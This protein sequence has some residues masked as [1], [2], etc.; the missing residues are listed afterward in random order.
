MYTHN[1]SGTHINTLSFDPEVFDTD[2]LDSDGKPIKSRLR[3]RWDKL[4]EVIANPDMA[5]AIPWYAGAYER[6]VLLTLG[7]AVGSAISLRDSPNM[8]SAYLLGVL[9]Y[10]ENAFAGGIL[11]TQK[12]WEITL[13]P[14]TASKLGIADGDKVLLFRHPI[15]AILAMEVRGSSRLNACCIGLPVGR[16]VR[17]GKLVTVPEILGGDTDGEGY[18]VCAI[19]TN[20]CQVYVNS[21][22]EDQWP[23]RPEL[24]QSDIVLETEEPIVEDP[25]GILL[26]K[27]TQKDAVGPATN[28]SDAACCVKV[29]AKDR[30]PVRHHLH[31]SSKAKIS[32]YPIR[33]LRINH[34]EKVLHPRMLKT[35]R[36][37][38]NPRRVGSPNRRRTTMPRASLPK[39]DPLSLMVKTQPTLMTTYLMEILKKRDPGTTP[40]MKVLTLMRVTPK[41]PTGKSIA[42]PMAQ[43]NNQPV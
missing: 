18:S 23:D 42:L 28:A 7:E 9:S 33:F 26:A 17:S 39:M 5:D 40:Q 41:S 34:P 15:T 13:H 19:H 32:R 36:M 43:L 11:S 10:D 16:I 14:T 31:P 30:F 12:A 8:S 2:L 25:A 24:D 20:E 6:E 3:S 37:K 29:M 22:F 35:R 27:G 38:P 4:N 1:I 21:L